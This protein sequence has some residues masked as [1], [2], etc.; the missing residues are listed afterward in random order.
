MFL[1]IKS[2]LALNYFYCDSTD[3]SN[4]NDTVV[5]L[6]TYYYF[7][8]INNSKDSV[9]IEEN[10]SNTYK[11]EKIT[12]E[13]TVKNSKLNGSIKYYLNDSLLLLEGYMKNNLPDST[14][15]KYHTSELKYKIVSIRSSFKNGL[16]NG[17][18]IEYDKEGKVKKVCNYE[19]GIFNG[20]YQNYDYK[21]NLLSKGSYIRG[22]K[23]GN[24]EEKYPDKKVLISLNYENDILIDYIWTS[25]YPNGNVF[26]EGTFDKSGK[27]NGI[28]TTYDENGN[29]KSTEIYKKGKLKK[30]LS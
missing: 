26:Y 22:K 15:V 7:D 12:I 9:V 14:F 16:K 28:S 10:S 23:A 3:F 30:V 1:T 5:K 8:F 17:T 18:E 21:G 19:N 13:I 11:K 6:E 4:S 20:I 2:T 29:V 25:F 24:W 27:L